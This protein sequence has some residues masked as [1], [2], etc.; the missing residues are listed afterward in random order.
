[1]EKHYFDVLEDFRKL[2]QEDTEISLEAK[3]SM[4]ASF[5]VVAYTG[6]EEHETEYEN[7]KLMCEVMRALG[8][9]FVKM[10]L[11]EKSNMHKEEDQ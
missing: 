9:V 4:L 11:A 7:D 3:V 1:M 2:F 5:L 10:H 6:L 8:N